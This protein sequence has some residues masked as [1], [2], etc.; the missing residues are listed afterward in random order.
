[1]RGW[2]VS[3]TRSVRRTVRIGISCIITVCAAASAFAQGVL[4]VDPTGRSG[5][6]PPLLL[7][8]P[9][10][11]PP[12]TPVLPPL[13]LPP[14]ERA[15][16][17][18]LIRVFVREITVV[19]NTVFPAQ[20][21]TAL[22]APYTNRELTTE[23][24]EALRIAVT[25][26]YIDKGYVNSGAV[27]PDQQVT[28]GV[29]ELRIIEGELTRVEVEGN[30]RLSPDY[31]ADRLSLDTTQ[32]VNLHAIQHRLQLLQQDVH[33][34]RLNAELRPGVQPGESILRVRVAEEV[35]YSVVFGFNNY[36]SPTV[37]A[38]RGLVSVAHTNL[39]G[40]GDTFAFTYGHSDGVSPQIDAGYTLPLTA[41]DTTITLRYR[42]ND[43]LVV[44]A[45][46]EPLDVESESNIY[47][48]T[49]RH[50][51]FRSL[52]QE[53]A[54]AL[55]GERLDNKTFLLDE[56]FSFS[57]GARRGKSVVSA[58]RLSLEWTERTPQQIIATRSRFSVGIDALDATNNSSRLPDGQFF[59]WL[60][61]FQWARRFDSLWGLQTLVRLDLQLTPDPLLP[62]E[63]IA[64]GGRYSVRGYRE[65][66]L[67]RDNGFVAA[68]ETGIPLVRNQS[69]AD[70]L[71]IVPFV[72]VGHAWTTRGGDGETLAS[73]G[74]GLRWALTFTHPFPITPQLEV[75]W[76]LPLK[77][78][79]TAEGDLQDHG[80]HLQLLIAMF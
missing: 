69:W 53:F 3:C 17:L 78:V 72:D 15:R 75:Y 60:G 66:Q 28:D 68:F 80:I 64:V 34:E 35:P 24:L 27:I 63:Q 44:E 76:G 30:K 43:F 11:V 45:P 74:V 67:V 79:K 65:N 31:I 39:T 7:E 77:N 23:D 6:R 25:R 1:M 49:L 47:G 56:R 5:D 9:A 26:Y 46:F 16:Q 4:G 41:R 32:P 22:T 50:P 37:G 51:F 73:V 42:R 19:G 36:Q 71:Q 57:P 58:L 21:L 14:P 2:D 8:E 10:P 13:P 18:P 62:L 59:A 33:I 54:F 61:Q 70:M 29:I 52:N 12:P 40:F 20:D 38:E 55:T 48:V